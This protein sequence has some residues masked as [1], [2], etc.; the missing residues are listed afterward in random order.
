MK[1]YI[2]FVILFVINIVVWAQGNVAIM[3]NVKDASNGE[4]L[5]G[6]TIYVEQLKTGTVTNAFGFYSLNMKPGFYTFRVSFLGYETQ[7]FTISVDQQMTYNI[8]LGPSSEQLD[9][10]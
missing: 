2:F 4:D 1:K 6:A 10:V 7:H 3:G 8:K 9:E 5:I